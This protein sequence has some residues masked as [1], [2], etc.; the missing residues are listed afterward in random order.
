[1]K[2]F[3]M[4]IDVDGKTVL[5]VGGGEQAAQKARLVLKTNARILLVADG[6]DDELAGL[7]ASGRA[8]ARPFAQLAA[9]SKGARFAFIATGCAGADAAHAAMLKAQGLLVN[10]VDRPEL[11][12][13]TTPAIVDRDPV[14][15]A[16]GTEGTAPVLAR[17]IKTRIEQM[18]EPRLGELSALAG[19]LRGAVAA[20]IA[21]EE[22][23]GFWN[24]VFSGP[25][26]RAFATGEEAQGAQILKDAIASG[27]IPGRGPRE[28]LVS[29]VGA[30]PGAADLI[31]L[32]GVQ[33][34][35]EADVIFYDRLGTEEVLELARRDAERVFVGKR[36]GQNAWPQDRINGVIVAAAREGK[37]VVRLK[38]GDPLI[39]GRAAEEADACEKAGVAWEVVPGVTSASAAA[40]EA[41]F[42]PTERGVAQRFTLATGHGAAGADEPDRA[43]AVA[44][45]TTTAFYMCVG[46]AAA[47]EADLRAAGVPLAAPVLIVEAAE[48]AARREF[49]TTVSGLHA[50]IAAETVTNPALIFVQ[51][52]QD[53]GA[54]DLGEQADSFAHAHPA[55][56]SA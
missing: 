49:R 5:I 56:L 36:V 8:D 22:H 23:R 26:R 13:L 15:I 32:R 18:L 30:G 17:Q 16:I 55:R 4:F 46:K 50:T 54:Q 37:R 19:R 35:Q 7:I 14:V 51:W 48:S 40:A 52:P 44:R 11:C 45:G 24:W 47:L 39:F 21:R 12:D 25:A 3:P 42:F 41:R 43:C 2:S 34:L 27:G 6:F 20:R 53:L 38:S 9:A 10:V 28:G 1:M 31:T 33:R 29:L